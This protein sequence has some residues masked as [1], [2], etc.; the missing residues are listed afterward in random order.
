MH[1][2][3]FVCL[4]LSKFDISKGNIDLQRSAKLQKQKYFKIFDFFVQKV[5]R[6]K[7]ISSTIEMWNISTISTQNVNKAKRPLSVNSREKD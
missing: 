5:Q 4:L 7:A 2:E 1:H 6:L 3:N